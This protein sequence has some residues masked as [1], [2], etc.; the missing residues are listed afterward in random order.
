MQLFSWFFTFLALYGT[1]LNAKADRQG[2]YYWI[3][4]DIAFIV[5]FF[6]AGLYA[7]SMLFFVYTLLAIKGLNEWKRGRDNG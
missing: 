1:W 7:Q 4:A 6:N 3:L 5:I 2:F